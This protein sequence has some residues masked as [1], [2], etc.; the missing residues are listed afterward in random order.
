MQ[1]ELVIAAV[2]VIILSEVKIA[3]FRFQFLP[4]FSLV[5]GLSQTFGTRLLLSVP[6]WNPFGQLCYRNLLFSS[7]LYRFETIVVVGVSPSAV[8]IWAYWL[9]SFPRACVLLAQLPS[10]G[11]L[12]GSNEAVALIP[13]VEVSTSWCMSEVPC[14]RDVKRLRDAFPINKAETINK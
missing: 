1:K 7:S 2:N 12:L 14:C 5:Q 8:C 4:R 11:A 13:L 10:E 9:Q 6:S 3:L